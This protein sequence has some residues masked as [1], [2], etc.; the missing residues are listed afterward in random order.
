ML[1]W[2]CFSSHEI[3]EG[4]NADVLN[5]LNFKPELMESLIMTAPGAAQVLLAGLY[6]AFPVSVRTVLQ[7]VKG[8]ISQTIDLSSFLQ[9]HKFIQGK[10]MQVCY[11]NFFCT[12]HVFFK[13]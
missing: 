3:G 9:D 13:R 5:S 12:T 8:Q 1:Y 7:P 10:C 2:V 11:Q 4:S 6:L